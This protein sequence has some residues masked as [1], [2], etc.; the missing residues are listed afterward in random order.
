MMQMRNLRNNLIQSGIYILLIA[1]GYVVSRLADIPHFE[2]SKEIDISNVLTLIITAWL[3]ILITT[4][5]EKKNNNYRV[6]KDLIIG[7][8]AN[9]FDIAASL[10][11]E[12]N[13]GK[14]HYTEAS[15]SIKRINTSLNSIYKIVDKCHFRISSDIK[16]KLKNSIAD[17]REILT[18]TPSL[19]SEQMTAQ[20]LPIEIKNSIIYYNRDRVSQIEVKFDGLKD[21]LLELQIDINKK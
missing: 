13:S 6:E 14:I 9:V 17:L 3:A 16:E 2:V 19:T 15:S 10:Q 11:I 20:E 21:L 4:V 1:S 5:F 12:S 7:R 8:V 18:N